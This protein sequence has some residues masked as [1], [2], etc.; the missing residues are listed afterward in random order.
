MAT[1][2]TGPKAVTPVA[3]PN[4][5]AATPKA[6]T[7]KSG[8]PKLPRLPRARK[9]KPPKPCECGCGGMTMGGRFI[10]GHDSRLKGWAIRIERN[11]IKYADIP[12]EGVRK[13]VQKLMK[14][15]GSAALHKKADAGDA[16]E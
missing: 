10:P 1:Q 14:A 11:L 8:L 12:D 16:A 7:T 13:A 15:G 6:T 5:D 9:A 2:K 4:V 3:A